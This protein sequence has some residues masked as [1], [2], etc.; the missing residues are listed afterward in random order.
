MV[1]LHLA[2]SLIVSASS[3]MMPSKNIDTFT[4]FYM[5]C[6]TFMLVILLLRSFL[7]CQFRTAF[8]L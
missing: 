5:Y 7:V 4:I 8:W 1:D 3:N 6:G 2:A